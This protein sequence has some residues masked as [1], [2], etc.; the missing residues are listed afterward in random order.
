MAAR[1]QIVL[2]N[3]ATV[4]ATG[5]TAAVP[6]DIPKHNRWIAFLSVGAIAGTSPTL[7]LVIQQSCDGVNWVTLHSFTQLTEESADS[8]QQGF[9]AQATD[10][11]K[12]LMPYLR[13]ARTVGGSDTPT[14]NNVTVKLLLDE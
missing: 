8:V 11:L 13:V 10:Y 1:K 14:F 5:N 3:S 12:P 2:I 7:D 4:T 6:N 9:A